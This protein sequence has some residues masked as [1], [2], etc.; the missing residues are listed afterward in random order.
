MRESFNFKVILKAQKLIFT[1]CI[2]VWPLMFLIVLLKEHLT[3]S[4]FFD[5]KE[6]LMNR[7][8]NKYLKQKILSL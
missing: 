6:S 4:S 3:P 1:F 5:E 7:K 8:I 2:L